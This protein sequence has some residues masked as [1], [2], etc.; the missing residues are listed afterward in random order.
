MGCARRK[1]LIV[2]YMALKSYFGSNRVEGVPQEKARETIS[3]Y[4]QVTRR[5]TVRVD[6]PY[7]EELPVTRRC[8]A[9][10]IRC[11]SIDQSSGDSLILEPS[12]SNPCN[13][14]SSLLYG[15]SE[16][17][18][19]RRRIVEDEPIVREPR[20]SVLRS[21]ADTRRPRRIPVRAQLRRLPPEREA[22]AQRESRFVRIPLMHSTLAPCMKVFA[23]FSSQDLI[24]VRVEIERM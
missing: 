3:Q 6:S 17:P 7:L 12:A 20:Y 19:I 14:P 22:A 13:R 4:S 2:G 9:G 23:A 8:R 15:H 16:A 21:T 11:R 1:K 5:A 24:L 18:P 10:Q